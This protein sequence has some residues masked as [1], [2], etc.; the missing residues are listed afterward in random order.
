MNKKKIILL[1]CDFILFILF[2]VLDQITK[3]LAIN[4]LK[5]QNDII[6]IKN[7]FQLHYLENKGAA[8][9]ML[10]DQKLFFVFVAFIILVCILFA[11][12]KIPV[13]KRYYSLNFLLLF[14]A[15]GAAGNMLDRLR[16]DYVVDFFYFSLIDFPVFN[17]ADIYVTVATILLIC[18]IL[19]YYKEEDLKFLQFSVAKNKELEKRNNE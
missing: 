12:I 18:L 19:F 1:I 4:H 16:F 2:I 13:Q 14:I 5:D 15:S 3:I 11:I 8:F 6:I 17:V 10:K 9:G 7:V